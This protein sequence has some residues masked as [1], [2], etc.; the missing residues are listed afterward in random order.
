VSDNHSFSAD[1][2]RLREPFDHAA[3]SAPLARRL[4]RLL[5][6]APR[7]MELATGL[8]S[9]ARFLSTHLNTPAHWL[10]VDHD[11]QLLSAAQAT[12]DAWST[13][14]PAQAPRSLSVQALD[15]RA[16]LPDAPCDAVV[17]QALLDLVSEAWLDDLVAWLRARRVP[18]LGALSV[19]GRVHWHEPHPLDAGVQAAFRAHQHLDRGFGASPGVRAA[20]MLADK[21][22]ACGFE[23][24]SDTA[25]WHVPPDATDMLTFM[26][27]GTAEAARVTHAVPEAV[28]AWH[29]QRLDDVRHQRV[30]LTV[31][32]LD[33]L[34]WPTG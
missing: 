16:G 10:L 14:R 15:L 31:G 27:D 11:P 12:M 4:A 17:T 8:G 2:L 3:R 19:D 6:D 26:V 1:W 18:F 34:A 29:A 23:V 5:P 13:A 9:G 22:R 32:H 33:L 7:L 24:V 30:S 25:D 21:L 20:S 28:D